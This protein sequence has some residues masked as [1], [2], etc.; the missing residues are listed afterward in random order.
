MGAVRPASNDRG[1]ETVIMLEFCLVGLAPRQTSNIMRRES[2]HADDLARVLRRSKVATM[3]ELKKAL[4]TE[5]D[6]TVFRKL[7]QLSY[8]TS[9][10]HRGSYYTLDETARFDE[11]GLWSFDSV[12]FSGEGTLIDTAEAFVE[13]AE[14]GYFV[15]ELDGVL[16]VGTKEPLLRLV[17]QQRIARELLSG[18]YLYCSIEPALRQRQL[19]ARSVRQDEL[20]LASSVAERDAVDDELKA[21]MVLF[22]S[23]LNEKQRRLYAGLESLKLGYGGDQRIADFVGLDAHTVAKGRRELA[24][25]DVDVERIRK[26]GGGRKPAEKKRRKSSPGSKS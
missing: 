16:H 23:T 17:Q 3:P 1:R 5:V 26:A 14:A 18:L 21:S 20:T 24:Q 6:A 19:L 7:K 8:R 2:F 12:W 22:L 9:Y 11:K 15:E 4:G 25:H 10:S 13:N